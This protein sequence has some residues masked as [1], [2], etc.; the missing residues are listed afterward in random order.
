MVCL[1]FVMR[2]VGTQNSLDFWL[3]NLSFSITHS[4]Y[5]S[6]SNFLILFFVSGTWQHRY[7]TPFPSYFMVVIPYYVCFYSGV[8]FYHVERWVWFPL[9][10]LV[11]Q[12]QQ[13][14]RLIYLNG[15]CFVF[16]RFLWRLS[17]M[18]NFIFFSCHFWS[19]TIFHGLTL[20]L[21][22][23]CGSSKTKFISK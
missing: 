15:F 14:K 21:V 4:L 23:G 17:N 8:Y 11:K 19:E 9:N 7:I 5:V 16:V 6:F 2:S 3:G 12:T 22:C 20:G 18:S 1:L 10:Q 13:T